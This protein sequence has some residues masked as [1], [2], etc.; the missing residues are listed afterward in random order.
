MNYRV[1]GDVFSLLVGSP[2]VRLA[3]ANGAHRKLYRVDF[4]T[5]R[6]IE[7]IAP[8]LDIRQRYPPNFLNRGS[9]AWKSINYGYLLA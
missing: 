9:K 2:R 7:P 4:R 5:N 1:I 3:L 6:S 8:R